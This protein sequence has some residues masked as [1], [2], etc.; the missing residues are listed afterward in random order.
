MKACSVLNLFLFM[1]LVS[2]KS[3]KK[4]GVQEVHGHSLEESADL[5]LFLDLLV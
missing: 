2:F 4:H 3:L 5:S 1:L